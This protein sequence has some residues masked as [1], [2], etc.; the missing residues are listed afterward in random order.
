MV[1]DLLEAMFTSK[2]PN[3]GDLSHMFPYVYWQGCP[4]DNVHYQTQEAF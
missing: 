1:N 4:D 3:M 2:Q